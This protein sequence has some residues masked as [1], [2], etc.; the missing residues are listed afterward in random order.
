MKTFSTDRLHPPRIARRRMV[1]FSSIFVLTS[2][3][4]WFMA[5][6]LWRGGLDGT[7][8]HGPDEFRGHLLLVEEGVRAF[9]RPVGKQERHAPADGDAVV[10]Q[11]LFAEHLAKPGVHHPL[12]LLGR[13]GGRIETGILL[14]A[15]RRAFQ[16]AQDQPALVQAVVNAVR[17]QVVLDPHVSGV[18]RLKGAGL[19]LKRGQG[20]AYGFQR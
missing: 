16:H 10:G 11:V 18:P 4:T 7:L 3:A 13:E 8:L 20:S 12:G 1:F 6:L 15:P 2:F 14:V 9:L 17:P 5:D 19:R